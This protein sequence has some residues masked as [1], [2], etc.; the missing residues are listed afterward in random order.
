MPMN[1]YSLYI[2]IPFCKYRCAYCDF[3][4]YA[5]IDELIPQYVISICNEIEFLSTNS[6][7]SINI[8]TVYFGGGTPSL[9][10]RKH[11]ERILDCVHRFFSL[12]PGLEVTIEANPGTLSLDFLRD[13]NYMGVNRLSLGMQSARPNELRLLDRQHNFLDVIHAMDWARKAG[14]DNINLDLI[15]GLPG[16]FLNDWRISLKLATDLSPEH[17]SLYS[18]ILEDGTPFNDWVNRGLLSIPDQ[19]IGAEMYEWSMD[20]LDNMGYVQYE[21]SNW[22]RG[23]VDKKINA[24]RHNLQYWYN[25]HYLGI[26]AGAHGFVDGM[27]IANVRSPHE[28]VKRLQDI[29]TPFNHLVNSPPGLNNQTW[30]ENSANFAITLVTDEVTPI[31]QW[32]E[33]QE[34]M[35]MGL[36]LTQEGIQNEAFYNRFGVDLVEI[37]GEIITRLISL[38]LIQW[39]NQE[40]EQLRLTRRGRLLGNIVFREFV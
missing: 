24:C 22:A 35:L 15:F 17:L 38:D 13:I 9:L 1:P 31:D 14:I 27:R 26:G 34:T 33:M 21:I 6:S 16:Q 37:Y 23:G 25:Q 18:L 30:L 39:T 32:Q 4:T 29:K 2:H 28:Y 40:Q 5:G 19:D 20:F 12:Q 11:L 36:R 3:N 10:Q 8:H 7:E